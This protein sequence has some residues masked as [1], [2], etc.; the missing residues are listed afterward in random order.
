MKRSVL[1]F[2]F[3]ASVFP[4]LVSAMEITSSIGTSA[5]AVNEDGEFDPASLKWGAS[6]S[7]SEQLQE[8]VDGSISFDRDPVSGNLLSARVSYHTPFLRISAGPSFGL[9]NRGDT[10]S[11]ILSLYQPGLGIGFALTAPGVIVA[12]AD[13]DFS[14]P[15]PSSAGGQVF[16]QKS[17]LSAGF[18]LP[19]VICSAGISQKTNTVTGAASTQIRSQTDYGFYTETYKKGSIFRVNVDFI[20]RVID[21]YDAP[22]SALNKK[23]GNAVIGGG[24]TWAPSTDINVFVAGNGALYSFSLKDKVDGLDRFMFDARAGVRIV[25]GSNNRTR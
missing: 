14:L 8:Q 20:Y 22:G 24:L 11:D 15:P 7:V 13:A 6:F 21:F 2:A 19:N 9:L 12:S 3:F 10:D 1:L 5:F 25:T 18:Y 17:S 16:V 4:A 23:V